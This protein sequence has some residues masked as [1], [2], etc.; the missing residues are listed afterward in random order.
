MSEQYCANLF[1]NAASG[2]F[3]GHLNFTFFRSSK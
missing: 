1:L 3:E 2:T